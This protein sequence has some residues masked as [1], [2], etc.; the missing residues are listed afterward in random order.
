M[1][2][3]EQKA[4]DESWWPQPDGPQRGTA[5]TASLRACLDRKSSIKI[6]ESSMRSLSVR[7]THGLG[8]DLSTARS[9]SEGAASG[10]S[11]KMKPIHFVPQGAASSDAAPPSQSFT[12]AGRANIRELLDAPGQGS[13]HLMVLVANLGNLDRACLEDSLNN[14]IASNWHIALLQEAAGTRW[15][16]LA[17][18]RG[19]S[20][21]LGP[22]AWCAVSAGG[23]GQ[24]A[25]RPLYS[26]DNASAGKI[27]RAW[28]DWATCKKPW[29]ACYHA[30]E[31]GWFTST[32]TLPRAQQERIRVCSFHLD[33]ELAKE[34]DLTRTILRSIF[35]LCCRDHIRL[36]AGDFNA[37]GEHLQASLDTFT[38]DRPGV[39]ESYK[40]VCREGSQEMSAILFNWSAELPGQSSLSMKVAGNGLEHRSNLFF[41]LKETDCDAHVP[42]VLVL[43]HT[44][45]ALQGGKRSPE[46]LERRTAAKK[47]KL[48]AKKGR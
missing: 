11:D 10:S 9:A 44:E 47:A 12:G 35:G 42:L 38:A 25:I 28:V 24:K 21:S 13:D 8:F 36:L 6:T 29:A 43:A 18:A 4:F 7:G 48:K 27:P 23:T 20:L 41:G 46:A 1:N 30:V 17:Q 2:P 5:A 32:S 31:I 26:N 22:E 40:V 33:H 45:K 16:M 19:L 39:L 3:R 34:R 14:F 15:P 37:A